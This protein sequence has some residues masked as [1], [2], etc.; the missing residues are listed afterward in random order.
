MVEANMIESAERQKRSYGGQHTAI[1]VVRQKVLLDDPARGKLDP[2]WTG[3]W[4]VIRVK[5]PSHWKCRWAQ[6]SAY[7]VHIN[8]V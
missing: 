7:V 4:E 2:H 8:Q 1:S 6:E 5:E 3:P